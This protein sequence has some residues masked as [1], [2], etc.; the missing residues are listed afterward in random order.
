MTA[1]RAFGRLVRVATPLAALAVVV[2]H[3]PPALAYCPSYG[4][5]AGYA[6][7]PK[8]GTNPD[9][10][11]FRGLFDRLGTGSFTAADGPPV[12]TLTTGCDAPNPE[13]KS[14]ATFP[15]HLLYALAQQE[16]GWVQFC[17]PET[18]SSAV[19]KPS[20]TIVSFDCGYGV[21]QVTSGMH[22]GDN[23]TFDQ[24]RVASDV[25]YNLIVGA[26][27]LQDKWEYVQCVGDRNPEIVEDWYSALWAYNGLAY[28]NNPNNPANDPGRGPYNPQ[29]GGAYTYQE[30]ILGRM[31]FPSS[32]RWVAIKP[33]YPNRGEIGNTG[34]PKALSEPS[35][36]SPTSCASKRTVNRSPCA[37][38]PAN[39]AGPAPA[40]P[41]PTPDVDAG[42]PAE[43]ADAPAEETAEAGCSCRAAGASSPGN[44][45]GG[46]ALAVG[47][48][49]ALRARRRNSRR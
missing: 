19:G 41:P 1:R 21:A 37:P 33:A 29:N 43:E 42:A 32:G 39:D 10:A 38:P 8:P 14:A 13:K 31:E 45:P 34:T 6:V 3:A 44:V 46:L 49:L 7:E 28:V 24:D 22:S 25:L 35:C 9:A 16:S 17:V 26:G 23:P 20:R 11:T 30:R 27:I 5:S 15:C 2:S 40:P 18:P 47:L 12:G 48:G 4:T 36:A